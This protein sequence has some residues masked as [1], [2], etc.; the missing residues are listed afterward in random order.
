MSFSF[1]ASGTPG[2]AIREVGQQAAVQ[3][4]TQAFAD[5]VNDQLSR[6]PG[7][8]TVELTCHGHTGWGEAQTRGEISLHATIKV[9]TARSPEHSK[10]QKGHGNGKGRQD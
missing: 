5:A 4:V 2:E 8:A 9:T 1:T 3:Q 10:G 6:L 7:D